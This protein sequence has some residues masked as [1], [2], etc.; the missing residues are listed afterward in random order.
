MVL[1][2]YSY[3]PAATRGRNYFPV[4]A[5]SAT[6]PRS[7]AV[8]RPAHDLLLVSTATRRRLRNDEAV[9]DK[10]SGMAALLSPALLSSTVVLLSR[11][12][13]LAATRRSMIDS[14]ICHHR[15]G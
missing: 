4:I 2:C 3:G 11:Q 6:R 8:Y 14:F 9:R 13:G 12:F 5:S 7:P 1:Y 15:D 10:M